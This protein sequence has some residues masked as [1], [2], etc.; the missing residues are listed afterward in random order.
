MM[1]W[2]FLS[3]HSAVNMGEIICLIY[4]HTQSQPSTSSKDFNTCNKPFSTM[5]SYLDIK[6]A[7]P[8]LSTWAMQLVRDQVS[9]E[10]HKLTK[11]GTDFPPHL[12]Q[13]RPSSIKR[14][15]IASITWDDIG[16]FNIKSLASMFR[17][18][19][20]LT[21]YL[22]ERMAA[23][24]KN[25]VAILKQRWPHPIICEFCTGLLSEG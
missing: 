22:T 6:Y 23:K 11:N 21:W 9:R 12:V 20:S 13:I 25:G 4:R 15:E 19:A 24:Q 3:G 17:H 5:T 8:S 2:A 7:R 14:P 1:V 10:C 16:T 18:H